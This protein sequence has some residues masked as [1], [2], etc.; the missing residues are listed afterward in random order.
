MVRGKGGGAREPKASTPQAPLQLFGHQAARRQVLTALGRERLAPVLLVSGPRGVGKESFAFWVARRLLCAGG[1]P[2]PCESCSGCSRIAGLLHPDVHWFFPVPAESTPFGEAEWVRLLERIR[3][4][5]L[6]PAPRRFSQPASFRM[7]QALA[8]RRLATTKPFE[9]GARIFILGDYEQN[10]SDQVHNALLKILEEPPPR[11]TFVLTTSRSQG[12]PATILSRC[13]QVRL[14]PLSRGE[15]GEFLDAV[16]GRE[17]WELAQE[18]RQTVLGRAEG[19]P[20]RALELLRWEDN[21]SEE[22][23]DLFREVAE[24]GALASYAYM[25]RA[26]FRGSREDHNRRLDA[27]AV[28]WRD[29]LRLHA[30]APEDLARPDLLDLYTRAAE[31]LSPQLAATVALEIERGR[32]QIQAN[33]YAP[34]VFWSLFRQ[35]ARALEPEPARVGG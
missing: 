33:V 8:L 14:A 18:K 21:L 2:Q 30:G 24:G 27:L 12:L 1:A 31:R 32:E 4:D 16:G 34:L 22:A 15:M 35:M 13:T 23:V 6:D 3:T 20:G 9:G 10:P 11:T 28:V 7:H 29:L 17:G 26:S 19:R 25:M 5:P